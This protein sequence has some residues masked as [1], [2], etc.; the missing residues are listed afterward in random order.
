M[1][2]VGPLPA[3]E[4]KKETHWNRYV[5]DSLLALGSVLLLTEIISLLRLYQR[6]PDSFL[7]YLLLILAFASM[8][9]F[10]AALLASCAAFFFYDF[11]YVPPA[12]SLLV[13][14]FEDILA[15]VVFLVTAIATAQLA[16]ALRQQAD[17]ANRR[18]RETR[19]L[20]DLVRTTNHE[21]DLLHQIQIF[22]RAVVDVFS[23]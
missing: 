2:D 22:A 16:S 19:I 23:P 15:L 5:G 4:V 17:E 11:L 7:V 20:Y 3:L 8:R 21:E 10:Y 18:E 6:I 12:Y 1:S 14:K 9:G 13:A